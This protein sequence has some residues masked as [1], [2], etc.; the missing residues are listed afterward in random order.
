MAYMSITNVYVHIIIVNLKD[1]LRIGITI[2]NTGY[3]NTPA[4]RLSCA[5][6]EMYM[7]V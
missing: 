5:I 7:Y 6:L 1:I 4:A 2:Y 3:P